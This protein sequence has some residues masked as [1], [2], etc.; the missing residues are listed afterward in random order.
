MPVTPSPY[1][2]RNFEIVVV[3]APVSSQALHWFD[4][5]AFFL[6]FVFAS[7]LQAL[8]WFDTDAF[9]AEAARV[10]RPGGVLAVWVSIDVLHE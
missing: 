7:S 4:T 6:N 1:I 3:P 9:Y 5:D 2:P 8:H 10:L